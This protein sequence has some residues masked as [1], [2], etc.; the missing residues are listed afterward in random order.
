MAL[1]QTTPSTSKSAMLDVNQISNLSLNGSNNGEYKIPLSKYIGSRV[2]RGADWK[3]GKQDGGE[4]HVGIIRNFESNDEVVI[5][6]D[7]GTG[8]NYRCSQ[9]AFDIRILDS[10][11]S[12]IK[13]DHIKCISCMESGIYGIRW[14]CS[15]CLI[16]EN[17]NINLCTPCYMAD[18]H[19]IKHKFF[20]MLT[21][22]SEKYHIFN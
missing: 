1:N 13:H 5:V 21:Q 17:L 2:V 20:R 4:G 9:N 11:S 22:T 19:D 14:I 15:D 3:W 8:A 6:W 16:N 10:S 7:N 12:G 18:K